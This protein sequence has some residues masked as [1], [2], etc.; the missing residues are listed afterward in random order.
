MSA[1]TDETVWLTQEAY[2]KLRDELEYLKG[3][4]RTAV[5]AKIA[6]ARSEGDLSE[7]GGY[8]AAREEQGQQEARI[9]QLEA[10]LR[11]AKVE[12]AP[13]NTNQ[14]GPGMLV[15]VAYFGDEDDTDTF[16]LGSRELLGL[17]E[18]VEQVQVYSP[19]SPLG[20]AVTGQPVGAKVSYEA[21]NGKKIDVT[22]TKVEIFA[23]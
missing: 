10:V 6:E 15:T 3:E 5:T 4:G 16:L 19:Q 20:A 1:N 23:P 17:D 7:N 14:A 11:K 12:E 13:R 21:P 18:S 8:H 22:V 2:D 9:R